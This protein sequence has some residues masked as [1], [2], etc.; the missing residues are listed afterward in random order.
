MPIVA[1]SLETIIFLP[2]VATVFMGGAN[3]A[4]G[5]SGVVGTLIEALIV[6]AVPVNLHLDRKLK[7]VGA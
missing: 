6:I 1:M 7:A 3:A 2:T 5:K 4:G